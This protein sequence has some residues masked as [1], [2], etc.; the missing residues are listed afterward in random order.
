MLQCEWTKRQCTGPLP[1]EQTSTKVG[2]PYCSILQEEKGADKTV[3]STRAEQLAFEIPKG[4]VL[5]RNITDNAKST[6]V[7]A[8]DV[9]ST[10]GET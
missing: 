3:G 10:Q 1:D 6:P 7:C 8:K 9:L 5:E 4:D 2:N